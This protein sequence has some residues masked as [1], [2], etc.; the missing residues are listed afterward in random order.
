MTTPFI[1]QTGKFIYVVNRLYLHGEKTERL[2]LTK[3]SDA[4]A[5][6]VQGET[7][8]NRGVTAARWRFVGLIRSDN[9]YLDCHD[10]LDQHLV[11]VGHDVRHLGH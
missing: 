11:A 9:R 5:G 4:E 10:C 7:I 2:I 3:A 6:R 8:E 1:E